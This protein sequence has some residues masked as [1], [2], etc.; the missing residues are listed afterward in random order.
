MNRIRR[1]LAA[2]T[3]TAALAGAV[4]PASA[5]VF[6]AIPGQPPA[7][8]KP[9]RL[10]VAGRKRAYS[11]FAP[12][13][14]AKPAPVVLV[15]HGGMGKI[16]QIRSVG[17]DDLARKEG[18]IVVYPEADGHQWND[19]RV[20]T[21][22]FA[23]TGD[24]DDIGFFRA[25]L[26]KL[27][28]DGLA[29]ARHIYVTGVSG[30]GMMAFRLGCELSDRIAAIAPVL[31]L[32]PEG[33]PATC[34]L[35]QPLPVLFMIASDDQIVPVKG[36]PVMPFFS[37]RRD[38]AQRGRVESLATTVKFWSRR[39]QCGDAPPLRRWLPDLDP[40]DG[41]RVQQ[42]H[43]THCAA[44]TELYH[45]AG[46]GHQWPGRPT[47]PGMA[48]ADRFLGKGTTEIDA[49]PLIWAFFSQTPQAR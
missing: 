40:F 44:A 10:T 18:F 7:A 17:F 23:K 2:L 27:I 33:L 47:R 12:S 36:G 11:L 49:A 43:W 38:V 41:T 6:D 25:L 39:N 9:T 4:A 37:D 46:G 22:R 32:P 34:R 30:G 14:I 8:E 20:L 35:R 31:A 45:I 16:E 24:V 3:V 13:G 21:G 19:G 48:Y 26:D 15:L 42:M 29:D 1:S 28:A 5:G